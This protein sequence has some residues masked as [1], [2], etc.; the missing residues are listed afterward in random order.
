MVK[1]LVVHSVLETSEVV[2]QNVK[3]E[4]ELLTSIRDVAIHGIIC[5]ST[6]AG[7]SIESIPDNTT[8]IIILIATGGTEDTVNSILDKVNLPCLLF[9]ISRKNSL[10]AS[11][12]IYSYMKMRKPLKLYVSGSAENDI[13]AVTK[14]VTVCKS[15]NRVNAARLG[16]IGEPSDWLLTSREI[17]AFGNFS[18]SL[19]KLSTDE[20]VKQVD[21]IN[22]VETEEVYAGIKLNYPD[23]SV[24]DSSIKASGKVYSAMKKIIAGHRLDALTIRCFDLLKYNYTAC[25]GMSMC[26]DEGIVSGCEGDL[27]ATFTMMIGNSLAGSPCW[28][29]NPAVI[30]KSENVVTFA[31]C[32]VPSKMLVN[33]NTANLTTHMESG[34]SVANR[35]VMRNGEVT[36]FRINSGFN[37]LLVVTGEMID[38]DMRDP[39]LCRTQAKVRLN[40]SIDKWL[41]NSLGNHNIIL[42][43]NLT[44]EL[45]DFCKFT[46]VE[47]VSID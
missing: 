17:S 38:S 31:H 39:S 3:S 29:A 34:L 28:M 46:G 1:L 18:T 23:S 37:K 7:K 11:L 19:I 41:E 6:A 4:I 14:F 40:C 9:A 25:M 21:G 44:E 42:Y 35:G 24:A 16:L 26:N 27:P 2:G 32:T 43:G 47:L 5:N 20:L 30:N 8:G 33:I 12:E 36:I 22:E 10:A 15:I 45:K 13:E